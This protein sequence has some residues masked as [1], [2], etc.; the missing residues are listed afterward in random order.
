MAGVGAPGA[1][2]TVCQFIRHFELPGGIAR[3]RARNGQLEGHLGENEE[4]AAVCW[5]LPFTF[6]LP[7][8]AAASASAT[9]DGTGGPRVMISPSRTAAACDRL[10]KPQDPGTTFRA[11]PLRREIYALDCERSTPLTHNSVCLGYSDGFDCIRVL[12]RGLSPPPRSF[13]TDV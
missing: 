9:R 10:P 12:S 2:G 4:A 8:A 7:A 6:Q 13:C 1:F 11:D 5:L 3:A